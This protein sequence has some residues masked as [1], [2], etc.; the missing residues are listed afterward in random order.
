MRL[1]YDV[2]DLLVA[3]KALPHQ[4]SFETSVSTYNWT[5]YFTPLHSNL[6]ASSYQFTCHS[7]PMYTVLTNTIGT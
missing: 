4:S 3:V 7:G 2:D 1:A 6:A 5:V